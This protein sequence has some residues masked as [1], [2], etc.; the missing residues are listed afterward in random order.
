MFENVNNQQPKFGEVTR[1]KGSFGYTPKD[2]MREALQ[3]V[4][5]KQQN[6]QA[7]EQLGVIRQVAEQEHVPM[8]MKIGAQDVF[9]SFELTDDVLDAIVTAINRELAE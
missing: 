9:A 3:A 2:R 4:K 6:E 5:R 8:R 7:L 1:S